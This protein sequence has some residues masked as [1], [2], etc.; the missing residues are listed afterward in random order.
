MKRNALA[1]VLALVLALSVVPGAALAAAP[2]EMP[3]PILAPAALPELAEPMAKTY[4]I[5]MTA[6]GNGKAE[7]YATSAGARE[8][9]YFLAD[10][11]PGYRLDYSRSGYYKEHYDLEFYYIGNNIYEIVMPDGNVMLNLEFVKIESDSH[12][13]TLTVSE[14]GSATV[15]QKTAKDGESLFVTVEA[16]P[17][18]SRKSVRARSE[19][20]WN[21]GY[22]LKTVDGRELYE[23]IMPDEDLEVL[24]DFTRN[25]PYAITPYIDAPGGTVELSHQT[26]YELETVTVTAKPDR[27]YQVT[28]V[29][30]C[31]SQVTRVK[32]NVFRFSM[33]KSREEVH[34]SFAPV[35]YPTSV[36]VE[37]DMGGKAYLDME[38][39]TI[40]TTV[41]LTCLPDE[42]YRVAQVTGAELTDNGDN[43]YTFV[44]DC[45]PVELRVLFLRENNPFLDVNET[46]FFYDSVL[47]AAENGITSGMDDT[48]FGPAGLCNRAQVVTFLW[49]AAGSPEPTLTGNPFVD[50]PGDSWFTKAVLWALEN[51]ITA[52]M[53]ATHFNPGGVCNRAQVVT[54]LW[55]A[56]GSPAPKLT[57]NPFTDV[58]EKSWYTAPVLWALENGVTAG[59]SE[60]SFNP[61]GQCLRAHVV[62]FLHNASQIPEPEPDPLPFPDLG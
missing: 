50:V 18:Y 40:G 45:A 24:V 10:P 49:N 13:V 29:G 25:G 28:N 37:L 22:Y 41:T 48:H 19:S 59:A 27:G 32:E 12:D 34:V 46:H 8:S 16:A 7:L 53:D 11:D 15:D 21:E 44:M 23:I 35:V 3:E 20:G 14:G 30:C 58:P 57:E 31:F 2:A 62:T 36:S 33:P 42:G 1:F 6:A 47:W 5:T 38:G 54:L 39:A 26:A 43:T 9:V 52:G 4:S 56:H 60:T 17:G 55:S 61:G 51:N